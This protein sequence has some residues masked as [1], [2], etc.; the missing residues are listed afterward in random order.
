MEGQAEKGTDMR[1]N[2]HGTGRLGPIS[3]PQPSEA[4]IHTTV[5]YL[6]IVT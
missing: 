6:K 1:G 3:K 5:N 2:N 4:K